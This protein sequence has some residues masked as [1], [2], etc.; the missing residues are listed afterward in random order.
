M[1]ALILIG[2]TIFEAL[3]GLFLS[4]AIAAFFWGLVKFIWNAGDEK[5]LADGKQLMLWGMV[6]IFVIVSLWAIVGF[7][8]VSFGIGGGAGMSGPGIRIDP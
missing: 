2:V 5:N 6:G 1:E 4:A 7:I 8:Q 3:V